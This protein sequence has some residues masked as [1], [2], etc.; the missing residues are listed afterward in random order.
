MGIVFE[1]CK[2]EAGRQT[3]ASFEVAEDTSWRVVTIFYLSDGV[4]AVA[5]PVVAMVVECIDVRVIVDIAVPAAV[6]DG[7]TECPGTLCT[8]HYQAVTR[9]F[10]SFRV[11]TIVELTAVRAARVTMGA[12]GDTPVFTQ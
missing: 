10:L 11:Q 9:Q 3:V 6:I 12:D 7:T 1:G 5:M 8:G 4:V 2:A